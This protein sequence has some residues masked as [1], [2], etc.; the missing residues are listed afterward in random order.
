[1]DKIFT[2]SEAQALLP[3]VVELLQAAV[4]AKDEAQALERGLQ[5]ITAGVAVSGGMEIDPVAFAE[6]KT[7][8]DRAVR[9]ATGSVSSIRELG[10]L[11]KDLDSGL[12]DFPA[13]HD[14][15]EIY[16]CWKLGEER[17][18]WWHPV[19]EGVAGRR[20]IGPEF[21]GPDTPPSGSR[22]N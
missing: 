21:L 16:L 5:R 9:Q 19:D 1:M 12:L 18:G 17:I 11:V 14:G 3:R 13:R 8:R 20:P 10:V 22:P 2:L 6:K 7:L 15:E 4:A